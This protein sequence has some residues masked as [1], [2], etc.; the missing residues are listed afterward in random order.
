[1]SKSTRTKN[2]VE[3]LLLTA[4]T[5][6]ADNSRNHGLQ[7]LGSQQLML[8]NGRRVVIKAVTK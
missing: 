8:G 4:H 1:M 6:L 5:R 7:S 3:R 2:E